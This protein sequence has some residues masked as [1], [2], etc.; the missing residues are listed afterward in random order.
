MA[1]K[2]ATPKPKTPA[3]PKAAAP[4]RQAIVRPHGFA[5]IGPF[6]QDAPRDPVQE[7]MD[8]AV[9]EHNAGVQERMEAARAE[10]IR[11][12]EQRDGPDPTQAAMDA[13]V[14]EHAEKVAKANA[15]AAGAIDDDRLAALETSILEKTRQIVADAIAAALA[16]RDYTAPEGSAIAGET[17]P[18]VPDDGA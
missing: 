16:G 12:A 7:A 18:E 5:L 1:A 11:K 13:A 15:K 17:T 3:K 2:T 14:A 9:A 8:A 10:S 6:D 4:P